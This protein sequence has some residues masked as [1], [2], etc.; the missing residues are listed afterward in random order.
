MEIAENCC[1][2]AAMCATSAIRVHVANTTSLPL[3]RAHSFGTL[4]D[5]LL[6]IGACAPPL[7]WLLT[8]TS[9]SSIR[10]VLCLAISVL[11]YSS[12]PSLVHHFQLLQ[13]QPS[14]VSQSPG[15]LLLTSRSDGYLSHI[16]YHMCMRWGGWLY[17]LWYRLSVVRIQWPTH[18]YPCQKH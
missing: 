8:N 7:N 9:T 12:M 14:G 16:T 10:L 6:I 3:T 18:V 1:V 5:P 4:Q 2:N 13:N 11:W 17:A 15:N